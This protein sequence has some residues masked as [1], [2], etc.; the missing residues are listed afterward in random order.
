MLAL[1]ALLGACAVRPPEP[2]L[3]EEVEAAQEAVRE[4][5]IGEAARLYLQAAAR[6][7]EPERS[8][9][10]LYAADLR[11]QQGEARDA[12]EILGQVVTEE[13]PQQIL[14]WH[15][16]VRAG[17]ALLDEAP[18]QALSIVADHLPSDSDAAARLL[19][20]RADAQRML[21]RLMESAETRVSLD[22]LLRDGEPRL[23]NR[24]AIWETLGQVPMNRLRDIMPPPPDTLGAWVELA[25]LIRTQHLD[26]P[27]LEESL[28]LWRQRYPDHPA[29][30]QLVERF[31][32]EQ[33]ETGRYPQHIAVLLPLSGPLAEAGRSIRDG[34]MAGYFSQDGR[35]PE[36]RFHDVGNNGSDPWAA[37]LQ[38][39]QDGAELVIGPLSR[40]SVEVFAGERTLPVPVLALNGVRSTLRPPS[41]LYRFGLLPEDDAR[42]AA[43]QA[44]AAGYRHAVVLT[45]SNDWGRR[46]AAAFREAF[47]DVGGVVLAGDTYAPEARD[48]AGPIRRVLELD[49]S[50][51]RER[52]LRRTI[53]RSLEFEPR[54]RQDVDMV[55]IG[56]FP[57]QARLLRPQLRF[58][59][60][61]AL[62]VM[63]TSH[64]YG[65]ELNDADRDLSGM[66][67]TDTPWTLGLP[68]P[69]PGPRELE[70]ALGVNPRS[71]SGGLQA[72]GLDA[73]RLIPH[74]ASMRTDG[75]LF[76]EGAT[77][78]LSLDSTGQ[79]HRELPLA[80]IH[81]RGVETVDAN[82]RE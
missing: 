60:A 6:E 36:L 14:D 52:R 70:A 20:V 78:I 22:H 1:A 35:R 56:A 23:A 9:Y 8:L 74:L 53:G 64:V 44:Y 67:F 10:R 37:Y 63:A 34:M 26:P 5:Q 4:G 12:R 30:R 3:P 54:R 82:S 71:S 19:T 55:F 49:L 61:M 39:V 40:E 66:L 42:S 38:A 28:R 41:G 17:L 69:S 47:E 13:Q 43:R 45:P 80:R 24:L 72:L 50:D 75:S 51:Q 7:E 46:V 32:A 18:E 79:V 16:A 29:D 11:V 65:G 77:G 27:T 62:P 31:V 2:E 58:H 48:F 57:E 33:Q 59:H 15:A 25:F 68:V 73:Y 81:G 21:G 76:L